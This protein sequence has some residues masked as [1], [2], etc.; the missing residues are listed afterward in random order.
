[1]HASRRACR[2][3]WT[4]A[5]V[6]LR[7][8]VCV[9]VCMSAYHRRRFLGCDPSSVEGCEAGRNLLRVGGAEHVGHPAQEM[10]FII[11]R[12]IRTATATTALRQHEIEEEVVEEHAEKKKR[13]RRKMRRHTDRQMQGDVKVP[14][15]SSAALLQSKQTNKH[16]HT[17]TQTS[18]DSCGFRGATIVES[19]K[20]RGHPRVHTRSQRGRWWH[21]RGTTK[22]ASMRDDDATNLREGTWGPDRRASVQPQRYGRCNVSRSSCAECERERERQQ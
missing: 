2:H 14:Q 9:C 18:K 21:R 22:V 5:F 6:C 4:W 17:N 1:M 19:D 7:I 3:S 8:R 16:K 20:L 11:R 15:L 12:S 10:R 13:K